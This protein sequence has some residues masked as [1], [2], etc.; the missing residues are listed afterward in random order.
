[1]TYRLTKFDGVAF[2]PTGMPETPVGSVGS[3]DMTVALAGGA[4][5]DAGEAQQPPKLPHELSFR[6]LL[7]SD[8][9]GTFT[10]KL[11]GLT[12]RR[13]KSG[14]LIRV[15]EDDDSEQWCD[16][17]L[18]L[19]EAV[20]TPRNQVH[21]RAELRFLQE[22]LWRGTYHGDLYPLGQGLTQ[23]AVSSLG[24]APQPAVTVA[25]ACAG[26]PITKVRFEVTGESDFEWDAA[27][28]AGGALLG[29][30]VL[31]FESGTQQ[32]R[33]YNN[34]GYADAYDGFELG[35]GQAAFDWLVF[36]PVG[37]AK[38]LKITKT[39][40]SVLDEVQVIWYELWE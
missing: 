26:T 5:F 2:L 21:Q 24:T 29:G 31:F 15:N 3:V 17:R 28:C 13:G 8:D 9:A 10:A 4:F 38:T 18:M 16:A 1:M 32:V 7:L 23:I 37:S 6:G 27:R 34:L 35:S 11:A 25:V 22:S 36:G 20:R 39:G 14:V 33:R 30:E 40:G 19:V 12:A